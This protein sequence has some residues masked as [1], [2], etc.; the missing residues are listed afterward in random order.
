[1]N[2]LTLDVPGAGAMMNIHPETVLLLIGKGELPAAKVGRAYVL[3]T[4]DVLAYVERLV[5]Q[6]TAARLGGGGGPR[7]KRMRRAARTSPH[8]RGEIAPA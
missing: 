2:G 4:K 6:Q 1:M 8:L 3:L 5:I 7:P